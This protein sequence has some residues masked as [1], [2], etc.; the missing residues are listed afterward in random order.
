MK[1]AIH[2]PNLLPWLGFLAKA[3]QADALVLLDDVAF[4]KGGYTNRVQVSGTTPGKPEWLTVPVRQRL[5]QRV[6]EVIIDGTNWEPQTFAQLHRAYRSAPGWRQCAELFCYLF[7]GT[8]RHLSRLNHDL[9]G[10]LLGIYGID[11]QVHLASDLR[12]EVL[13][14]TFGLIDLVYAV[15]GTEYVAGGSGM[16]YEDAEAWEVAG[17]RRSVSKFVPPDANGSLSALHFALTDKDPAATL[18]ACIREGVE[19]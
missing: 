13:P 17:L 10:M 6:N 4:T 16:M 9:L 8:H 12:E 2:Q 3:A 7:D 18:Q 14:A 15:S 1:V 5:G 11:C 19:A